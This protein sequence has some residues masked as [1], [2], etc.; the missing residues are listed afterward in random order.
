MSDE[1]KNVY[2]GKLINLDQFDDGTF[3]L[4]VGNVL[5]YLDEADMKELIEAT[6]Q[7]N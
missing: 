1:I 4:S 6:T 7:L 3:A 5:L 2:E